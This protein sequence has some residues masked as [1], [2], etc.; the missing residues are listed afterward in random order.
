MKARSRPLVVLGGGGHTQEM[1]EILGGGPEF[2]CASVVHCESDRISVDLFKSAFQG[3]ECTVYA[4]PRPNRVLEKHS[5][6]EMALS[7][8]FSFLTVFQA[9][10]DFLLCNG[11]GLCAP[12]ALAYRILHPFKPIFY[13]ESVTRV[14][15]LSTTGK[16]LQYIASVFIVQSRHLER[17][18]YPH[19]T[20]HSV[21]NVVKRDQIA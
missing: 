7:L 10:S 11:P 14:R 5:L 8:F 20:Y 19:R 18:K 12:V 6:L 2:A 17:T 1:L 9:R 3:T 13:V 15:T 21:F 16:L 4:V